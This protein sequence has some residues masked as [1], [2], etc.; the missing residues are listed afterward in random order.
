MAVNVVRAIQS[1][2][3]SGAAYGPGTAQAFAPSAIVSV[4]TQNRVSVQRYNPATFAR[5]LEDSQR[6]FFNQ[7]VQAWIYDT[8]WYSSLSSI[9]R[10]AEFAAIVGMGA[11]ALKFIL[12]RIK[13]G[14]VRVHWFPALKDIAKQDPVSPENRG[15]VKEM[16]SD[17]LG[18]GR[19]HSIID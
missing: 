2:V 18:W 5:S 8:Q 4:P 1:T 11:P 17:W 3:S 6:E 9:T 12:E 10:H 7:R 19:A 15:R 13:N 14:D 16:A